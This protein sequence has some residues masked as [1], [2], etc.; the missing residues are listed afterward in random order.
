MVKKGRVYIFGKC[1]NKYLSAA[2][3]N[4]YLVHTPLKFSNRKRNQSIEF[5]H[6]TIMA[7][8]LYLI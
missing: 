3:N 4:L 2:L 5:K 7:F 8:M 1:A 6:E